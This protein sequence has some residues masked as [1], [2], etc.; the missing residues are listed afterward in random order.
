MVSDDAHAICKGRSKV[1]GGRVIGLTCIV[2]LML[3][4]PTVHA[5]VDL[6][7]RYEDCIGRGITSQTVSSCNSWDFV[8]P[9]SLIVKPKFGLWL[10]N[11]AGDV[12]RKCHAMWPRSKPD[13]VLAYIY[14]SQDSQASVVG[15]YEYL[16]PPCSAV[17]LERIKRILRGSTNP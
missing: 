15:R 7:A 17:P 6:V 8:S 16:P 14:G 4:V 3:Q 1:W 11:Q 5:E 9:G 12:Y 2:L 13:K 10:R